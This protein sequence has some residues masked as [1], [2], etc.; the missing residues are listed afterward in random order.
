[1]AQTVLD[2]V[3][4][5]IAN[6]YGVPPTRT[7]VHVR[8]MDGQVPVRLRIA[9]LQRLAG[10]HLAPAKMRVHA[11]DVAGLDETEGAFTR[12]AAKVPKWPHLLGQVHKCDPQ[13]E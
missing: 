13:R 6:G 8:T 12:G 1:M 5:N 9:G 10:N 11:P 3:A 7:C 2:L 4:P